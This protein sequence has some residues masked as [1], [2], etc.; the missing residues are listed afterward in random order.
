MKSALQQQS[1]TSHSHDAAVTGGGRNPFFGNRDSFFK[2]TLVQTKLTIG[3]PNDAYE[4]EADAMAEKVV[5]RL[6]MNSGSTAMFPSSQPS[7]QLKCADCEAEEK[8]AKKEDS[9]ESKSEPILETKKSTDLPMQQNNSAVPVQLKCARCE[10]EEN[11]AKKEEDE[12]LDEPAEPVQRHSFSRDYPNPVQRKEIAGTPWISRKGH[13]PSTVTPSNL[14]SDLAKEKGKGSPLDNK[15]RSAMESAFGANFSGVRVHTD[16]KSVQMNK[17]LKA[18][19]FT[20]GNDIYFNRGKFDT[21]SKG[22]RQLLAHELTHTIQQGASAKSNTNVSRTPANVQGLFGLVALAVPPLLTWGGR[23]VLWRTVKWGIGKLAEDDATLVPLVEIIRQEILKIPIDLKGQTIFSPNAVVA[24]HLKTFGEMS[25]WLKTVKGNFP[26]FSEKFKQ[27]LAE[28]PELN[29]RFGTMSRRDRV[30]IRWD[31]STNTYEMHPYFMDFT[32][33]AFDPAE[34]KIF[35]YLAVG[36]DK[37]DSSVYGAIAAMPEGFGSILA[38]DRESMEKLVDKT[39]INQLI[40]GNE[41]AERTFNEVAYMNAI[42]GGELRL[43]VSGYYNAGGN[44]TLVAAFVLLNEAHSF[45]ADIKVQVPGLVETPVAVQRDN[46]SQL[47]GSLPD[48]KLDSTWNF[49]NLTASVQASYINNTLEIRGTASYSAK[50]DDT[51]SRIRNAEMTILVTTEAKAWEE[52][53]Q[54]LPEEAAESIESQQDLTALGETDEKLV[55]VGWGSMDFILFRNE[56]GAPV[57]TAKAGVV[58]DPEGHLTLA[59]SIRV[60]EKYELMEAKGIGWTTFLHKDHSI[61]LGFP[62]GAKFTG[63]YCLLYKYIIG[64][65]TLYDIEIKGIYS[66]NS[67]INKELSIGAR[68]NLSAEVAGKAAACGRIAARVGTS[69]PYLGIDLAAATLSVSG[70]AS[71]KAYLDIAPTIGVREAAKEGGKGIQYFVKGTIDLAAQL[72]LKLVGKLEAEVLYK[73]VEESKIEKFWPLAS[74]G[75]NIA[76]DYTLGQKLDKESLKKMVKFKRSNFEG[77]RFVS[78]VLKKDKGD[79]ESK[80]KGGGFKDEATKKL[81]KATTEQKEI[82]HK[83]VGSQVITDDFNMQGQWHTLS[84]EIGAPGKDV[85]IYMASP[86]FKE[87]SE[88][89]RQHSDRVKIKKTVV[90]DPEELKRLDTMLSDLSTLRDRATQ[91]ALRAKQMGIDPAKGNNTTIPGFRQLADQLRQ[92]GKRYNV[93]DIGI[94]TTVTPSPDKPTIPGDIG[95][96]T[97]DHPIKIR[98]VKR[99]YHETII[100]KARKDRWTSRKKTPPEGEISAN[101]K[102]KTE[103]EVPPTQARSFPTEKVTIGIGQ[104]YRVQVGQRVKR[105]SG[106]KTRSTSD[107]FRTLLANYHYDWTDS[108]AD[109]ALDLGFGGKDVLENVWPIYRLMNQEFGNAVYKK[110]VEYVENGVVKKGI[111]LELRNKYFRVDSIGDH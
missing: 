56:E 46:R 103:L 22:G 31:P 107:K 93:N 23:Y 11:V 74:A 3:Q 77:G 69:F 51:T 26:L 49:N 54:Q 76:F 100:L 21:E 104:Q 44:Q 91:V 59:G 29:I 8:L 27:D 19:A 50:P 85:Q 28:G 80:L 63:E 110:E 71:L 39:A 13:S 53:K 97:Y 84:M 33:P 70:E 24:N 32:H 15:S 92:F 83:E 96:G 95:D 106:N 98:W 94:S 5:Q 102:N 20:H 64:P 81:T 35:P 99:G 34:R 67:K 47:T 18:H 68:L 79:E 86:D 52:V 105:T 25:E 4:K 9:N 61:Q 17:D 43:T 1:A 101:Y 88:K 73:G 66:T 87:L 60:E 82:P 58:L 7:V 41:F 48:I 2:P 16:S 111:P 109:H 30:R 75:V 37:K 14:S 62:V 40:F 6:S 108:D 42:S 55:L 78:G 72:G 57:V 90:T 38:A 10:A 65:V 36:I 45:S 12:E 89:V